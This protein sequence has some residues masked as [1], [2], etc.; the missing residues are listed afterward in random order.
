MY[1]QHIVDGHNAGLHGLHIFI[2]LENVIL[3]GVIPVNFLPQQT[4]A[5]S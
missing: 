1:H 4:R 3:P 5:R 2:V